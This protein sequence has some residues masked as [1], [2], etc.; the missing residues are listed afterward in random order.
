MAYYGIYWDLIP[1]V[2]IL[3]L[4]FHVGIL[5]SDSLHGLGFVKTVF[6]VLCFSFQCPF[7]SANQ[8]LQHRW[9]TE[10]A[11]S[12]WHGCFEDV[13][14]N[15]MIKSKCRHLGCEPKQVWWKI[16]WKSRHRLLN[17]HKEM[18]PTQHADILTFCIKIRFQI[19]RRWIFHSLF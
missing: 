1:N 2:T 13:Y 8:L 12:W 6:A 18:E 5:C 7:A 16:L 4:L 9:L 17:F 14:R 10:A 11:I 15:F 19:F 3:L